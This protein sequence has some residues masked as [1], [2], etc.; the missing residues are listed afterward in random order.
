[1]VLLKD[2]LNQDSSLERDLQTPSS[3]NS[4][5]C[6][7]QS[8]NTKDSHTK[9]GGNLPSPSFST[10]ST[11]SSNGNSDN[12]NDN[13]YD[14]STSKEGSVVLSSHAHTPQSN[15]S[16]GIEEGMFFC[17]WENC[18][19]VF[20]QP[21]FLYHHLCQDHVGRKSQKNLQLDCKWKNCDV[22]TEKRD[23]ITSHI[24]VHVPLKPFKCSNCGKNFKRPQ[25]LKKHLK[26]HIDSHIIV[27]KK[28][29][30]KMGSKRVN[31]KQ[32][33]GVDESKGK[34]SRAGNN[35]FTTSPISRPDYPAFQPTLPPI[36]LNEL[37]TKELSSYEPIYTERLGARLQ[38]IL[39]PIS[40]DDNLP[41]TSPMATT[42]AARFFSNLSKNMTTSLS[43]QYSVQQSPMAQFPQVHDVPLGVLPSPVIAKAKEI[44]YPNP[45]PFTRSA[46]PEIRRLP[47]VGSHFPRQERSSMLPSLSSV[48]VLTPRNSTAERLPQFNV[49]EHFF[50]STQRSSGK[51]ELSD[52]ND[53]ESIVA[54]LSSFQI[55]D[56]LE[57]MHDFEEVLDTVNIMKDYLFCLLLEDEYQ[58]DEEREE[59]NFPYNSKSQ[60]R[61]KLSRYPQLVI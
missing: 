45:A 49:P 38:T 36:S 3:L 54:K 2:I 58:E 43:N 16:F 30:P 48:P 50:S 41:R 52:E 44:P 6:D 20:A 10:S 25:D 18:G 33:G 23:H 12:D 55:D 22:K 29:G 31:R 4:K 1:M 57:E 42:N 8:T 7:A 35:N 26:I 15:L 28:R 60:P 27:K 37:V 21:E 53:D 47:P 32:K 17:G 61:A 24:R 5:L 46:Y 51:D 11:S 13:E 59:N 56:K 34:M 39:P 19:E 9:T 14:E 40:N